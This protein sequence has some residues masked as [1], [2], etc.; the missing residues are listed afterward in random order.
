MKKPITLLEED[1][2][3][4]ISIPG[5]FSSHLS[6]FAYLYLQPNGWF[7]DY[8][9]DEEGIT[10][11]MTYPSIAFMK[12]IIS[13]QNNVFEY[14]SGYSTLFF[15]ELSN[16]TVTVE[17]DSKWFELVRENVGDDDDL[18]LIVQ[19][20]NAHPESLEILDFFARNFPEVRS[21]DLSHDLQHGML[22]LEFAGYAS[23]L[24]NYPK[25][26]FDV[27][28]LDGM[29]RNLTGV[30][31]ADRIADNGIIVLD[32]SDRWQYNTLQKYLQEKGYKRI[33]FWGPGFGNHKSWCT[34]F[35]AKNMPF[36]NNNIERKTKD[37]E[38]FI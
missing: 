20:S 29:A 21:N 26:Y 38:L 6:T 3:K 24:Y 16:R 36:T 9:C 1:G 31:A 12:D 33:D 13:K 18:H 4:K 5:E 25:G 19:G 15:R 17:H 30:I 34:S 23:T 2:V 32:N 7:S 28:V 8:P 10:P 27:I 22:N 14:G 35:Y 37:G 11:W